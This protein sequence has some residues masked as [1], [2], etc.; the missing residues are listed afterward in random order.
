MFYFF[1][2]ILKYHSNKF[3]EL[4]PKDDATLLSPGVF[5]HFPFISMGAHFSHKYKIKDFLFLFFF[6]HPLNIVE[7]SHKTLCVFRRKT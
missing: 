4:K 5:I 1:L 6:L 2:T 7:L 3:L